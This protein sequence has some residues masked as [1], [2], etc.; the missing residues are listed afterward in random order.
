MANF[1]TIRIR[2][3]RKYYRLIFTGLMAMMMS[4]IISTVLLL[5]KVGYIDGFTELMHSWGLAFIVAWPSAYFC[6]YMVQEH[7]LSRIEFY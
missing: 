1:P 4:L 7:I 3:R 5:I 6:A 2:T